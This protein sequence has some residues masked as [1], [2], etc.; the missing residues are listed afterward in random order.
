MSILESY[1]L[2]VSQRG[3]PVLVVSGAKGGQRNFPCRLFYGLKHRS[4][5]TGRSA[6]ALRERGLLVVG[7]CT[8]GMLQTDSA[9]ALLCTLQHVG[10]IP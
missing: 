7:L 9:G 1:Q 4:P 10:I 2:F 5:N 6:G 8:D 3:A